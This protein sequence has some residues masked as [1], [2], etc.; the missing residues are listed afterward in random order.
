[1]R[2]K[3]DLHIHSCLSPCGSLDMDPQSIARTAHEKGLHLI[4]LTDHNCARNAPALQLAC[5]QWGIYCVGGV[6]ACSLEEVHCLCLFPT[7]QASLEFDRII[8]QALPRVKNQPERLGDQVV[9][10]S[11]GMIVEEIEFWLGSALQLPL[12]QIVALTR[13]HGGIALPAHIDKPHFSLIAQLGFLNQDHYAAVELSAG[14]VRQ[15]GA[16]ELAGPYCATTASDAHYPHQ[17]GTSFICYDAER[18]DF[19]S[20][21]NALQTRSVTLGQSP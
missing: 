12:E 15:G 5:E 3:A 4:A 18:A 17:I 1:M 19:D 13:S 21:A 20:L 11:E 8:M 16:L 7:V 10:D 6:E 14:Y 2:Y 9:V